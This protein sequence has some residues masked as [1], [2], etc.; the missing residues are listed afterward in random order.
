MGSRRDEK[1]KERTVNIYRAVYL[2]PLVYRIFLDWVIA[3]SWS[4]QKCFTYYS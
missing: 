3:G 1:E 2:T 4:K